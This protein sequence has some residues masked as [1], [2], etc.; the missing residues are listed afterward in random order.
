MKISTKEKRAVERI[1]TSKDLR[2][3]H[4]CEF[5]SGTTYNIS[6]SGMF[7]STTRCF[8]SPS[9]LLI[10]FHRENSLLAISARIK[11]V[12]RTN[13]SCNGIGVEIV[14]PRRDY[15]NFLENLKL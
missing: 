7:I 5:H 10:F 6:D 12:R 1:S 14:N 13:G 11:W 3:F 2:F 8:P 15:L 4:G 9:K